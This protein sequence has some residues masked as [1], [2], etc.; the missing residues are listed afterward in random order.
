M[1]FLQN[2]ILLEDYQDW[3]KICLIRLLNIRISLGF[4][5][6]S[7]IRLTNLIIN[8]EGNMDWKRSCKIKKKSYKR[9]L[10]NHYKHYKNVSNG[11]RHIFLVNNHH[12]LI[13]R[14]IKNKNKLILIVMMIFMIEL[15]KTRKMQI[16]HYKIS[17]LIL[18]KLR[19]FNLQQRI[20]G[21]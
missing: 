9:N 3:I 18:K 14:N 7:K 10:Y 16:Y 1:N 2:L 11:S 12:M 20:Y 5:I 19:F 21:S 4:M 15:F 6:K 13:T 8:R 17:K